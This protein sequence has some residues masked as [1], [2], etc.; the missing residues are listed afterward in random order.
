MKPFTHVIPAAALTF[1][2]CMSP[3]SVVADDTE[4]Y[5]ARATAD[6]DENQLAANV[7]ILVDTSGSMCDPP[8]G[9]RNCANASTPMGALRTAFSAM[10]DELSEEVKLGLSKFNGG[11]DSSGYGGYVFYDVQEM[12]DTT[13]PEVVGIVNQLLGTSN[14]PTM[15]AYSESARYMLGLSPTNYAKI[16]EATQ[17]VPSPAVNMNYVCT[18]YRSNG[19]CRDWGWVSDSLYDSPVTPNNQ[20][21]TNHIIVMTDGAPTQDADV[22]SVNNITGG[23]CS[24]TSG[25]VGADSEKRSF[26]CQR[27]LAAYLYDEEKNSKA[28]IKTWQIAFGVGEGSN[29][30]SN[31]RQVA[32]A[33]GTED[34]FYADDADDLAKAFVDILNLIDRDSRAIT[35]PAVAVNTLSRAFHLDELYYA[36]FQPVELS[37]WEGNLKRYKLVGAE[38]HGQNGNAVDGAT[39]FFREDAR[40]FW[41]TENDGRD[42]VKG[43]ARGELNNRRLFFTNAAGATQSLNWSGT[44]PGNT[45]FGL[46]SDASSE[47]RAAFMTKLQSVW[48]DP[49]HSQPLMVNYGGT[50]DNNVVFVATNAGMLH[51]INSDDGREL[52]AFMP[53]EMISQA[54]HLVN[55]VLPLNEDNSRQIYGLDGSWIAWRQSGATTLAEPESVYLYGGMRRGGRTYYS[56]DVSDPRN[57]ELRWK[58]SNETPGFE[59]LGQTWSTP[60]LTSI[61]YNGTQQPVLIFGGGYSPLDHDG[62]AGRQDA[63]AMGNGVYIVNAESGELIWSAGSG[64]GFTHDVGTMNW[65]VPSSVA[66]VDINF[67]GKAD[68]L[69]FGDLGGQV[70]R[71]NVDVYGNNNHTVTRIAELG[72]TGA[73]HRRFYEAP[74]VAYSRSGAN[75]IFNVV[76]ASGYRAHPLDE[77]TNEALFMI[78][79]DSALQPKSTEVATTT[80]MTDVTAGGAPASGSRGWYYLLDQAGEKALA[81]PI[82]FNNRILMTTYSPEASDTQENPCAVTYGR[83]FLHTVDL[84][85][86][87]PRGLTDDVDPPLTRS[88]ALSLTSPAPSPTILVDR[89]GDVIIVT[90]S[91]VVGEGGSVWDNKLPKR[92]WKQLTR[93]EANVIRNRVVDF[94]DNDG[95]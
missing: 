91:E 44:V 3:L 23:S 89:D 13:K 60:T 56:V 50:E 80:N 88:Q 36:V 58:I 10:V 83:T 22:T 70:F 46:D 95:D 93:D 37:T 94:E 32:K 19:S 7:L 4:I 71:V 25:F 76:I 54:N 75:R 65:A 30:V 21:E 77:L 42:V 34:V 55:D 84:A 49:L 33:G 12:N 73:D 79:D 52:S 31:M 20:C 72:G 74:A 2:V 40:S 14:T 18:R 45:F 64:D 82:I 90:G 68:Y 11:H 28:S 81:S 24:T 78:K 41:S 63:D 26:A 35:A 9:S 39:G 85:T 5:F 53:Y 38:I 86:A 62:H 15:E 43:G 6:N 67:D 47:E 17:N 29:E 69:F 92:R 51:A 57:P 48:G 66:V 59:R 27:D 16:G 8:S 1:A 87:A 61:Q